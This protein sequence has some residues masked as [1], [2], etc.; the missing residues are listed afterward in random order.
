MNAIGTVVLGGMISGTL[1]VVIFAP[2]FY[3]LIEMIFGRRKAA[4]AA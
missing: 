4:L 2:L 3:V 1:L